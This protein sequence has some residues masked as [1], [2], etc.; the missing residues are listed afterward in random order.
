MFII[1]E[2]TQEISAMKDVCEKLC[3]W[4]AEYKITTKSLTALFLHLWI[5]IGGSIYDVTLW[6]I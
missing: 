4:I 6:N 2:D 3:F 5:I 1:V